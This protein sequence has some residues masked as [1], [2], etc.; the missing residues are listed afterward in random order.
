MS[1]KAAPG[2]TVQI[3]AKRYTVLEGPGRYG[4]HYR[5][6]VRSEADQGGYYAISEHWRGG[7]GPWKIAGPVISD[8]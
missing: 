7:C 3:S 6:M 4:S 2:G 1:K 8:Q 5:I